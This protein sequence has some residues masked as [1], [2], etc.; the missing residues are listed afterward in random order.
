MPYPRKL[1]NDDETVALDVHPH[2]WY[3]AG[4]AVALVVVLIVGI[5]AAASGSGSGKDAF[6]W[7]A[8]VLI[9]GCAV[10]FAHRAT[11]PGAPHTS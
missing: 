11:S 6:R 9:V 8:V 2:W 1:L 5:I 10:W 7:V 4:P 3:F